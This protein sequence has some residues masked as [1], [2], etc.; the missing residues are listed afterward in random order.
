MYLWESIKKAKCHHWIDALWWLFLSCIGSLLPIWGLLFF[1]VV[2]SQE[3]KIELFTNS[4]E[5]ALY[6]AAT[7][8]SAYYVITKRDGWTLFKA[9]KQNPKRKKKT[10][11]LLISFPGSRLFTGFV[12]FGM[13]IALLIFSAAVISKLPGVNLPINT[14]FIRDFSI[15]LFIV[16][17]IASYFIT[18]LDV[19]EF[20]LT[21][22]LFTN[23]ETSLEKDFNSL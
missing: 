17:I 6:S 22:E 5:F 13:S 14:A 2:F 1:L 11:N 12:W 19:S 16:T 20:E 3:I 21:E 4:G 9:D 7:L 15:I 10:S 18:L 8:S 23:D